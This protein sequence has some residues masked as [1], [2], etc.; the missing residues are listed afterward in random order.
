MD[1]FKIKGGQ[2]LKGTVTVKG[3]KNAILPIMSAALL[4]PEPIRLTNVSYLSDVATLSQLLKSFGAH[5]R[6]T[7]DSIEIQADHIKNTIAIYDFVS[8]MRASFWVLGPLLARFKKATVSLPGGCT[9]GA[10]PVDIYLK[11][12]TEMGAKIRIEKGYVIAEGPLHSADIFFRRV[13]VGATHNT[14]MAAVLTPGTTTLHNVAIEPE[15][16]D[17]IDILIKMGAQIKWIAPKVLSITG[18][19]HLNGAVHAV[20]SDRIETATFI[21][22]AAMT[23]SQLLIKGGKMDHLEAFIDLLKPSHVIF[24]Q[25][26]DG[27]IVDA[28]NASLS[29]VNVTTSEYPGFPTDAQALISALFS[30]ASG[31]AIVTENLFENRFMHIPELQRMGANI[32][33]SGNQSILIKGVPHLCGTTVMASDLRAGVALVLAG[34]V[35]TGETL[36]QRIY[37]VDR[38]YYHLEEKLKKIGA[39]IERISL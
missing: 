28:R 11:A 13:S 1:A 26:E 15:V 17:L 10:R 23:K 19:T 2:P 35:A 30:I 7:E 4:T 38:G 16:I 25:R 34:L 32:Q 9:I 6:H 12:L 37:H 36:V 24:E 5:V 22:A 3:A 8:R 27:L 33:K 14:I 21:T 29:C 20:V 18:V 39:H 31:E